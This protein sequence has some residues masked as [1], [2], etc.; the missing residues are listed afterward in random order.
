M[1]TRTDY[2]SPK[3]TENQ[4]IEQAMAIFVS[5]ARAND[6]NYVS[7]LVKENLARDISYGV[8]PEQAV[9]NLLARVR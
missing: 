3:G 8:S 4:P 5:W 6:R 1:Y 9:R 2:T 7:D